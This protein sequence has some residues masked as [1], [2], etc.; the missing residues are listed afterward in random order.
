MGVYIGRSILNTMQEPC[1][2]KVKTSESGILIKT[3]DI[4]F[5]TIE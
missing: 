2:V 3:N 4:F 5:L 1:N